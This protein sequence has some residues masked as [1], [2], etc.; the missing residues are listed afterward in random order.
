VTH[1]HLVSAW[2]AGCWERKASLEP[3]TFTEL[4]LES[5]G[6]RRRRVFRAA[7]KKLMVEGQS[8]KRCF[9]I[10][11]THRC[12]PDSADNDGVPTDCVNNLPSSENEER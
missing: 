12:W 10:C 2:Q 9:Q 3:R 7:Q 11:L 6:I 1:L 8:L 4:I 5:L